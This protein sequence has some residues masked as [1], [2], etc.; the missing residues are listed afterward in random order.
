MIYGVLFI[1]VNLH[2]ATGTQNE[3]GLDDGHVESTAASCWLATSFNSIGRPGK[4]I[5]PLSLVS[6]A[7]CIGTAI[8]NTSVPEI[9]TPPLQNYRI[10]TLL[11]LFIRYM[12]FVAKLVYPYPS[13]VPLRPRK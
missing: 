9:W 13:R 7:N 12:I 3:L 1:S 2:R 4:R 5:S 8:P 10:Y 11:D 6:R